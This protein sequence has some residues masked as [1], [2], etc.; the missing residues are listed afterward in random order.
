MHQMIWIDLA[1]DLRNFICFYFNCLFHLKL[2]FLAPSCGYSC[3]CFGPQ[4]LARADMP[5]PSNMCKAS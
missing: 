4:N 3:L 1:K 2:T 5:S